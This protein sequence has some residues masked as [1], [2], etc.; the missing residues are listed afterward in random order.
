MTLEVDLALVEKYGKPGPRYT[1]YPTAPHFDDAVGRDELTRQ[2]E[3]SN[4]DASHPLSLYLHLPFCEKLC[5]FCGCN[6]IVTKDTSKQSGYLD[7]LFREIDVART[8]LNA[9][10]PVVQQHFGGG[11]PTYGSPDDLRRIGEKL[12]ASFR[13]AEGAEISSEMDPRNLTH[14]HIKALREIGCNRAS[15]GVQDH[16]PRVQ[17][18][19]H[20]IQPRQ[21]V[22]DAVDWI[23]TEGFDSINIDL[24][25]GL[26]FQ[27]ADSFAAT[28]QDVLEIRPNRLAVFNYAH[29]PWMKAHQKLIREEDL[30]T[31]PERL[32]MLKSIIETLTAGGYVY[33]GMD[34]FALEG[35]ELLTAQRE[36][37]LR[38]NFQGY[39]TKAGAEIQA[40]GMSAISQLD[41]MYSQNIKE[42]DAYYEKV[43]AGELPIQRGYVLTDDDVVRRELIMTLMC[44]MEL[45]FAEVGSRTGVDIPTY[46]EGELARLGTFVEDGLL[47]QNASGLKVTEPG[48]LFVRNIAMTFDAHLG[49]ASER[50]SKTV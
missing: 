49:D 6:M 30:P 28:L 37:T 34:H 35:D 9:D 33:V 2:L 14:D 18:A 50:Y 19:I 4:A 11:T 13:Y 40:F 12:H 38:R 1:S 5:W 42:V 43:S 31:G 41:R 47:E 23:R 25:Y 24:I 39:S 44:D 26:P 29:V 7:H 36:K 17:K 8:H 20:R 32:R 46:F 48:R 21:L 10:R 27:S 45:D 22:I 3:K 15:L 16:D